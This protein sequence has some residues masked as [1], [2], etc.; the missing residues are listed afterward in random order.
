MNDN[1]QK[2]NTITNKPINPKISA[3]IKD[4]NFIIIFNQ[5]DLFK[6]LNMGHLDF[7]IYSSTHFLI[8]STISA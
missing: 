5:N 2:K 8:S 6:D 7:K 3:G 1:T 4:S